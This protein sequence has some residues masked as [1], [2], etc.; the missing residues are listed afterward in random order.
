MLSKPRVPFGKRPGRESGAAKKITL[1][2]GFSI[3]LFMKLP[4]SPK[5]GRNPAQP[6]SWRTKRTRLVQLMTRGLDRQARLFNDFRRPIPQNP[7]TIEAGFARMYELIARSRLHPQAEHELLASIRHVDKNAQSL[8]R[9]NEALKKRALTSNDLLHLIVKQY[10][11]QHGLDPSINEELANKN[12]PV[13]VHIDWLGPQLHVSPRYYS[14]LLSRVFASEEG[15]FGGL[16]VSMKSFEVNTGP[17]HAVLKPFHFSIVMEE[18][19]NIFPFFQRSVQYH[20]KWHDF[21]DISQR[22]KPFGLSRSPM[23]PAAVRERIEGW[24]RNELSATLVGTGTLYTQVHLTG[25]I[26]RYLDPLLKT[27]IEQTLIKQKSPWSKAGWTKKK[28][29]S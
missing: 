18:F 13:H 1:I 17:Y 4:P 12:G 21:E 8:R 5:R 11:Q 20:E 28:L 27:I 19:H 9:L 16:S 7:R 14:A 6:V 22:L 3:N 26:A 24:F 10:V 29:K 15:A 2:N 25:R 23:P